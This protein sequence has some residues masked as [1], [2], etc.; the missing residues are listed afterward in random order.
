MGAH[1]VELLTQRIA[2]P[3]ALPKHLLLCPPIS[4]RDSVTRAPART[5]EAP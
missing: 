1:A 4:L 5:R 3:A 2:Y